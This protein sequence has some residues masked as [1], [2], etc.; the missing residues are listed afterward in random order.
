MKKRKNKKFNFKKFVI[1]LII[2]ILLVFSV[3]YLFN[4][5]TKNIIILNNNY[6]SDEEII[7]TSNLENYPKFI[8]LNKN[9]IKNKLKKLDL[10]EDVIV[11]KKW[12][13]ILEINIKLEKN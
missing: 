10:I 3:Y 2:I 1:F 4:L 11:T 6:Y 7:E 12:G 8:L 9:R 13:S 5:K